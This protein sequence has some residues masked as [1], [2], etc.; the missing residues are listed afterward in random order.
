MLYCSINFQQTNQL[1]S[2][3]RSLAY[4][5]GVFTTAKISQGRIELIDMHMQRLQNSCKKIAISGVDFAEIAQ[6]IKSVAST[7]SLAVL[8]VLI[9]AGQGGRGYSRQGVGQPTV[10]ISVH[11]F[12]QHYFAWQKE[13]ISVAK[14]QFKLG[15]NPFLAGVKT[16][17]P[18]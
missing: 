17:K 13:G 9:S 8:K 7:Y 16:L 6:Q 3:D 2:S 11:E 5:D 4:G 14:S 18:P 12:P 1:S 15:L 10:M